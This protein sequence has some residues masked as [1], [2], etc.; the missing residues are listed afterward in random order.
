MAKNITIA[1]DETVAITAG[2]SISSSAH[3][4]ITSDAGQN[5]TV[6]AENITMVANDNF[7]KMATHIEKT[8]ETVNVNSTKDNIELHSASQIVNK[9]GGKVKLF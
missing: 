4:N 1:A 5:H 8:A 7:Q 2:E 9:S 6:M 3:E